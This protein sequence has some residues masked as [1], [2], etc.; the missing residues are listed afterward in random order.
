MN[1][2]IIVQRCLKKGFVN[3]EVTQGSGDQGVDILAQKD[4]VKYAIQ[5]KRHKNPLGNTPVQE[6]NAGKYIINVIL[7][8]L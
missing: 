8:L 6:V 7:A 4:D 3:V 1:L 2:N 5:C